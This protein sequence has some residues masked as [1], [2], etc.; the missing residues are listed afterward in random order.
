MDDET[1]SQEIMDTIMKAQALV[2]TTTQRR[3]GGIILEGATDP[4]AREPLLKLLEKSR[5]TTGRA[6]LSQH[7]LDM[8]DFF[9]PAEFGLRS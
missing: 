3:S 5:R 6:S 9:A 2:A 7:P 4:C 1:M 8:L